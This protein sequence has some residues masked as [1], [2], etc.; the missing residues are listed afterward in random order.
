MLCYKIKLMF[1]FAI[2]DNE[3]ILKSVT[4]E[5][6]LNGNRSLCWLM[7]DLQGY[8]QKHACRLYNVEVYYNYAFP[9][10]INENKKAH[11]EATRGGNIIL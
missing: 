1:T 5:E 10:I 3:Q 6:L 11:N 2:I 7:N 4:E 9:V 8:M